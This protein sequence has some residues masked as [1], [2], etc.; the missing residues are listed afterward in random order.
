MSTI[1]YEDTCNEEWWQ[2][3]MHCEE[4]KCTFMWSSYPDFKEYPTFCPN[5]GKRFTGIKTGKKLIFIFEYYS[6]GE[7]K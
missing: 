1:L 5:C 7:K 2:P 6:K 3:E 4:C